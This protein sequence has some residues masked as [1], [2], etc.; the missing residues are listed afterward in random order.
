MKKNVGRP[1][2][3][4]ISAKSLTKRVRLNNADCDLIEL[5]AKSKGLDFSKYVRQLALSDA[6][7]WKTNTIFTQNIAESIQIEQLSTIDCDRFNYEK[8]IL[9][10][11][12]R[13]SKYN[14]DIDLFFNI[15]NREDTKIQESIEN[16]VKANSLRITVH[17]VNTISMP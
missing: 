17:S 4:S 7:F 16:I 12:Q 15:R 1:K 3:D 6:I 14:I 5:S 2:K 11:L 9:L 10:A 8:G 13:I